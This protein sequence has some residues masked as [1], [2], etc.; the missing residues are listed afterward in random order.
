HVAVLG[1]RQR[2]TTNG[3]GAV[4]IAEVVAESLVRF[5]FAIHTELLQVQHQALAACPR[6]AGHDALRLGP[7]RFRQKMIVVNEF[8]IQ[9]E[10]LGMAKTADAA[11]AQIGYFDARRL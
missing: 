11:A 2:E 10:N 1:K 7:F 5:E 6:Y 8:A 9:L 3:F 4:A